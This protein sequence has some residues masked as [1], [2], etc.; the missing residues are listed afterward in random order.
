MLRYYEQSGLLQSAR[1]EDYAYRVYDDENIKRLQRIILLRKLQIPVKQIRV[2]LNSPDAS[3]AIDIFKKNISEL[4]NEISALMTVKS[5]LEIF[6]VKIE[7]ISSVKLNLEVLTDDTVLELADSLSL[8]QRNVN[9]NRLMD[10]LNKANEQMKKQ[11]EQHVRIVY[12]P[13]A[14]MAMI[15]YNGGDSTSDAKARKDSE[16][17]IREFIR[18]TDL[19]KIKPDMRVFGFGHGN[20][21]GGWEMWVSIPE[22]LEVNTPLKKIKYGGGLYAVSPI[23][24]DIDKWVD[25]SDIY[26]WE[27]HSPGGEEYI[28]PFNI[29]G[30]DNI[31]AETGGSM[32]IE[33][34]LPVKEVKHYTEAQIEQ[35]E[36]YLLEMEANKRGNSR[37]SNLKELIKHGEF[38]LKFADGLMEMKAPGLYEAAKMATPQEFTLPLKI[39]LRAKTN[40]SDIDIE[41][42]KGWVCYNHHQV[43]NKWFIMDVVDGSVNSYKLRGP[44]VVN[45]FVDIEWYMGKE[46]MVVKL[47]GE[48]QH[49]SDDCAYI[50]AFRDNPEFILSAAVIIGT[51]G[52]STMTV[53]RLRITELYK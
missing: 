12:R 36:A 43:R 9:E 51:T 13:P 31:N 3:T 15:R 37:D 40:H 4:D 42:A 8:A 29:Y 20:G 10:E 28:N 14:T 35:T 26:H 25:E 32:Y 23:G 49:I 21:Y 53:E 1:K 38:D 27:P 2:I 41:Y 46:I 19:F 18:E 34:A 39:E 16:K 7:E 45:E 22:D 33:S 17:V 48:I 47:N 5:A 50:K 6:I 30:L 52:K 24:F 11:S 44:A